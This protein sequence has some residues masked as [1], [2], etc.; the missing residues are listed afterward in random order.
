[1]GSQCGFGSKG[2]VIRDAVLVGAKLKN[3]LVNVVEIC[4]WNTMLIRAGEIMVVR[5]EGVVRE[6]GLRV[7]LDAGT[8]SVGGAVQPL[9]IRTGAIAAITLALICDIAVGGAHGW[10][11]HGEWVPVKQGRQY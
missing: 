9:R 11:R 3:L 7:A 6:V 4:V 2:V 8:A 1:M 10:I 5:A